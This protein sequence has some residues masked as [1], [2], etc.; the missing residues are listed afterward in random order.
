MTKTGWTIA[1]ITMATLTVT[2]NAEANKHT[3]S[4]GDSLWSI[5][6]RYGCKVDALKKANRLRKNLIRPGDRLKLPSSCTKRDRALPKTLTRKPDAPKPT[7]SAKPP[8]TVNATVAEPPP[9]K[10]PKI[11]QAIVR[12]R[13]SRG[14][15]LIGLAR[16]Y[17]SSVTAIQGQ[18][19]LPDHIIRIGEVIKIPAHSRIARRGQP[20]DFVLK[21]VKSMVGQSLGRASG[22]RLKKGTQL[23]S[24][25]AYF[26]R[27]PSNAWGAL[28]AV[29]HIQQVARLV[30]ARHPKVH[31]L[32]VGDLSSKNG[33]RLKRHASHQSG[34]DVDLGF[35]FTKKPKGYPKT[36]ITA[37][38]GNLN[39]EAT[40]TMLKTFAD[41]ADEKA[42]V[43]MM[44]LNYDVQKLI[45]DWAR[46][47]GVAKSVLKWM[48]QYPRGKHV[49]QGLI[50]HEPGH[51]AHVH[52][53]FKCAPKDKD[54]K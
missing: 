14:D 3:V 40:W 1:A 48:F 15:T 6:I 53:R 34:R 45:Y 17:G 47:R 46:E 35:Y 32:A 31:K 11:Q 26:R 36:F 25:K 21:P 24:D 52:V 13:V 30:K 50:R 44:F 29:G 5:S 54:C 28:H 20:S 38:A 39:F 10:R 27:R 42:G 9:A 22:G 16:R 18:N 19:D 4:S 8:A 12:Y 37:T 7:A 43:Y 2:V 33:G 41:T 23:P 49:R 51:M